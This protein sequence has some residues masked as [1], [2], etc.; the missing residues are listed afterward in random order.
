MTSQATRPSRRLITRLVSLKARVGNLKIGP[1]SKLGSY[2]QIGIARYSKDPF[3]SLNLGPAK[4]R[5]RG[6]GLVRFV[7]T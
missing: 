5:L 7:E 3:F 6:Y 1:L 2:Y 4:T